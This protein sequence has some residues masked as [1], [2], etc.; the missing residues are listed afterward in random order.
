MLLT[1]DGTRVFYGTTGFCV[2]HLVFEIDRVDLSA[3]SGHL[4]RDEQVPTTDRELPSVDGGVLE[5]LRLDVASVDAL[6]ND[7]RLRCDLGAAQDLLPAAWP[8]AT[9]VHARR[10]VHRERLAVVVGD[11]VGVIVTVV[12]AFH[13]VD[14]TEHERHGL[15]YRVTSAPRPELFVLTLF[16]LLPLV[17]NRLRGGGERGSQ[18]F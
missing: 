13:G 15:R 11:E 2:P 12:A 8:S 1:F 17:D 10:D 5:H 7:V 6:D 3:G 9:L 18:G 4:L 14:A 16:V